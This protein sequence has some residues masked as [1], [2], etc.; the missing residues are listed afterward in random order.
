MSTPL[1]LLHEEALRMTHPVFKLAPAETRAIFLWD[2]DYFRSTGYTLK[3]LIFIYETLCELPVDIIQGNTLA[4][5]RELAPSVLYAPATNNPLIVNVI[6]S[7]KGIAPVKLVEDE[8]F[9][10]IKKGI[11]FR[12]FFQYWNKAEKVA[13]VHNGGANA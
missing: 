13:F 8:A 11:K 6:G 1:I 9:V 3:R 2:E 10:M 4:V 5:I 7:L 12:R